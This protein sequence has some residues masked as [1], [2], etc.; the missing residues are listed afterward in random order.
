MTED[1]LPNSHLIWPLSNISIWYII[2][3]RFMWIYIGTQDISLSNE[4]TYMYVCGHMASS[5]KG[6]FLRLVES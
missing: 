5:M 2:L 3:E 6:D 4:H 1:P